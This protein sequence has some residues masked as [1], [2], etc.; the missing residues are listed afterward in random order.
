MGSSLGRGVPV[1]VA[2]CSRSG[3]GGPEQPRLVEPVAGPD[4]AQRA[5]PVQDP[6]PAPVGGDDEVVP[7]DLDVAHGDPRQ[8]ELQGLPA[9]AVVER[10][11][12]AELGG[13]VEQAPPLGVLA[14]RVDEVAVADAGHDRLPA[15]AA[16]AGA[17]DVG[18]AVLEA[19]AVHGDVGGPGVEVGGLDPGDLGPRGEG[20][21]RDVG[22]VGAAVGAAPDEAVVGA[23]PQQ[24]AVQRR[25]GDGVDHAAPRPRA[26]VRGHPGGLQA[27]RRSGVL[28][29]EVRADRAPVVATVG[30]PEQHLVGEVEGLGAAPREGQR[31]RPGATVQAGNREGRVHRPRLLGAQVE[32]VHGAAVDD[33]RGRRDR[34]RSCR[35]RR[36]P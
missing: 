19:V 2:G 5:D 8:V 7:V 22:P 24:P 1:K 15:P 20:R 35:T 28:A 29:G 36:R 3:P 11:V 13:G 4:L 30:G 23:D 33:R 17:V 18:P 34:A 16:V 31:Q 12:H 10:D 21:G 26:G 32:P 25:R 9:L 27:R 14:D 6:E